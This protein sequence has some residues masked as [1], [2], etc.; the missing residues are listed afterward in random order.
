M[1]IVATDS[2]EIKTV[3]ESICGKVVMTSDKPQTGTDRVAEAAAVFKDFT[4]DIIVNIQ[5]DE[6]L[7]PIGAINQVVSL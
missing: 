6:P 5:G 7:M 2:E 3:V 1:V 4:P